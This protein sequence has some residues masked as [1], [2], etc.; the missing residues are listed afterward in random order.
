MLSFE[1][2]EIYKNI[3][4]TEHVWSTAF[5]WSWR[6]LDVLPLTG[7]KSK[8]G[9]STSV[10]DHMLFCDHIIFIDELNILANSDSDFQDKVKESSLISRDK[11]ILNKTETSLS[12]Y[13][14]DLILPY[15]IIF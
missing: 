10:K 1:I 6:R 7:K 14:F 3:F 8:P 9:K 2:C 12:L 11:P 15:E 5:G 4:F 13:L